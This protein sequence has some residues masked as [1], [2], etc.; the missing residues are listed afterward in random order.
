MT[1]QS[2]GQEW[3]ER[4]YRGVG[5]H[6]ADPRAASIAAQVAALIAAARPG[7]IADHVGST[8]VPGLIGKNVVD[9]QITADPAA[10]PAITGTLIE[11]GFARQRDR[12]PWPPE[13]PMLEGT[14]RCRGRVFLMHCHVVPT[15]DP[16]VRQMIEFRDLL[17]RDPAAR[18]AYAADK[19]RIAAS[20]SDS[21]VYTHA[22]TAL[23]RRLLGG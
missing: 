5:P 9:L 1:G 22:K 10:V 18:Q 8:A 11:L 2:V 15:T 12:E 13:R 20:T 3:D 7:T 21:L 4:T 16:D 6:R 23:I 19:R 14:F 17:R